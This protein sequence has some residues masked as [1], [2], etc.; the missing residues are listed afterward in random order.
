MRRPQQAGPATLPTP[1]LQA[2][3]MEQLEVG[4]PAWLSSPLGDP[5]RLGWLPFIASSSEIQRSTAFS[6][7]LFLYLENRA[8]QTAQPMSS[9]LLCWPRRLL[10]KQK[11]DSVERKAAQPSL[12]SSCKPE[13]PRSA[14]EPKKEMGTIKSVAPEQC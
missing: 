11:H 13:L 2:H 3:T 9:C 6:S 5:R 8:G 14:P 1:T 7:R 10:G 4:A 12:L